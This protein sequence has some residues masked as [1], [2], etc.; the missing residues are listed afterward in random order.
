MII[1]NM[2]RE[3]LSQVCEIEN[4]VFSRPWSEKDFLNS[5]LDKKN[6]YLVAE[7][8]GEILGYCGLW[9]VAGEGQINNVAVKESCRRRKVAE[10]I[11]SAM[12]EMGRKQ[13]I[14]AFTLEVRTGNLP[15]ISLYHRL[16]FRDCGLRKNF[17]EAP[18][19]DALIMWL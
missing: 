1:R 3:D 4:H 12:L 18:L 7:E 19:E 13:G 11:L 5:I 6:I 15:A 17:Y 2:A 14:E 16:G 8:E 9:D 10:T